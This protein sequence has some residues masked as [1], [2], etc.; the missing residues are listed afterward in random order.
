MKP[1][2]VGRLIIKACEAVER[3]RVANS[4]QLCEALMCESNFVSARMTGA[5]GRGLVVADRSVW[6]RQYRVTKD[7]RKIVAAAE[8][9]PPPVY[10]DPLEI[11]Y[12]GF[13][14]PG[15]PPKITGPLARTP[16]AALCHLVP[17]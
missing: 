7:W 1:R 8:P 5:I 14:P 10:F 2:P 17:A 3:L 9:L 15:A 11:K 12:A 16:W 13:T 6:P 4:A